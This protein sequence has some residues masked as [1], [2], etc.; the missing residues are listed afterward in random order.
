[1]L[2]KGVLC[3]SEEQGHAV[4]EKPYAAAAAELPLGNSDLVTK[5]KDMCRALTPLDVSLSSLNDLLLPSAASHRVI[6]LQQL[7]NM[8]YGVFIGILKPWYLHGGSLKCARYPSETR[9]RTPRFP[10]CVIFYT[11][12]YAYL[13]SWV[14]CPQMISQGKYTLQLPKTITL[15]LAYI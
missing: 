5:S 14:G 3:R 8:A 6:F 13:Q 9:K 4:L 2:V 15:N 11:L 10:R 1:M 7:A 12:I